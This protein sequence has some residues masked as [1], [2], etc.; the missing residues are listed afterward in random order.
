MHTGDAK[1]ATAALA[2]LVRPGGS[3][4]VHLYGKG[5][6]IYEAVDWM[7]RRWTTRHSIPRLQ[8]VT[9]RFFNI[10]KGSVPYAPRRLLPASGF[11][12]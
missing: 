11:E 12:R 6:V 4:T 10:R 2:R 3:L 7:I 1:R 9:N 8:E 5:N